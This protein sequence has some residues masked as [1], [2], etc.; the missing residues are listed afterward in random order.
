[1]MRNFVRTIR[2]LT[3]KGG[4]EGYFAIKYAEFAKNTEE[5]RREYRRLAE[6]VATCIEKGRLLEIGP[7]PGYIAIELSKLG[8]FQITGL[9]ISEAMIEIAKRNAKEAN[10]EVEFRLGDAANMPLEDNT[11]DFIVSSGSLHH[12]KDPVRVFNEMHRT[13]KTKGKALVC[14]VRRDASKEELNKIAENVDSLIMRWGLRHSVRESYIK[15][16]IVGL[17]AKTKF[18]KCKITETRIDL[19]IWLEK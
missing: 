19:E 9:D 15:E 16:E 13:L 4:I 12:W 5:M 17:I 3:S 6:S 14:D 7:G 8:N 2:Q 11:F 1:M 18:K 10:A